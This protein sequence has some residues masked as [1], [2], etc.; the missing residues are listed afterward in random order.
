MNKL[1]STHIVSLHEYGTKIV[2]SLVQLILLTVMLLLPLLL[3]L[4][5][6]DANTKTEKKNT[7]PS[8]KSLAFKP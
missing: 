2:A 1:T 8:L 3:D 6:L 5:V 4:S 7:L